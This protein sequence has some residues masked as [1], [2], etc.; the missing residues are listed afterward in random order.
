MKDDMVTGIWGQKIGMTQF[1][2]L[3]TNDNTVK[4]IAVTVID[5]GDWFVTQIKTDGKDGYNAI[6]VGYLKDKYKGKQFSLE[7]LKNLKKY[8][9]YIREIKVVGEVAS[10]LVGQPLIALQDLS[11]GSKVDVTGWS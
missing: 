8:F 5:V 7:W 10:D 3:N 1:F 6:Q 2:S 9:Q 11:V 4:A